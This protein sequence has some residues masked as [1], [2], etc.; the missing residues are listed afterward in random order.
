MSR[1]RSMNE[2]TNV[3]IYAILSP[4]G[5]EFY[6][7]K[8]KN[9]NHYQA[10]KDH[11]RLR[12]YQTKNLFLRSME[13]GL[14]PKMYLLETINATKAESY[15]HCVVW[16]RYFLDKGLTPIAAQKTIDY[17]TDLIDKNVNLYPQIKD[18]SINEIINDKRLLVS[19]YQFR[20]I[21]KAKDVISLCVNPE[22]YNFIQNQATNEGLSMSKYCR[23][24]ALYGKIMRFDFSEYSSEIRRAKKVLYEIEYAILQNK[25]YYPADIENLEKLVDK[26][27]KIQ[28]DTISAFKKMSKELKKERELKLN[29]IK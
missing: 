21:K 4:D 1:Q 14:F 5:N 23:E 28:K 10:Y 17:A 15:A 7:G 18:T 25:R 9:P 6:V 19:N 2:K 27:N 20:Q 13:R 26:I 22:E 29:S 16:T 12:N 3:E 11:V 24:M 8:I